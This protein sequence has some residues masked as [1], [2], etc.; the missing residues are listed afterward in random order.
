MTNTLGSNVILPSLSSLLKLDYSVLCVALNSRQ[1]KRVFFFFFF[2]IHKHLIELFSKL[3]HNG[4]NRKRQLPLCAPLRTFCQ[5]WIS[6]SFSIMCSW[7]IYFGM[8][9]LRALLFLK[10]PCH[11]MWC[12][13]HSRYTAS[14]DKY[15]DW[16]ISRLQQ[17]TCRITYLFVKWAFRKLFPLGTM[18]GYSTHFF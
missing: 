11:Q 13:Q 17:R 10:N 9:G 4:F 16:L 12:F 5:L 2:L 3:S 6:I 1:K 7:H 14:G 18:S 15:W 8:A